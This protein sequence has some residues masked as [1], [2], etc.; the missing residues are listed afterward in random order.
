MDV[1]C[2]ISEFDD[3]GDEAHAVNRGRRDLYPIFLS[4]V[5]IF[6]LVS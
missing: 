6:L 1:I 4:E 2:S 3:S 5:C